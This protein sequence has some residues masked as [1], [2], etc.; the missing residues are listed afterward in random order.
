MKFEEFKERIKVI[1]EAMVSMGI[2]RPDS[3]DDWGSYTDAVKNVLERTIGRRE[4]PGG[5]WRTEKDLW[6]C[7][8]SNGYWQFKN[9]DE[10]TDDD[11]ELFC[12]QHE[13]Y[14]RVPDFVVP[15]RV[16][17][18]SIIQDDDEDFVV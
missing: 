2:A 12:K 6:V 16:N 9:Y 7:P 14:D 3:F 13:I 5:A 11:F 18:N 10:L 15:N 8:K 1:Q 4:R 17:P